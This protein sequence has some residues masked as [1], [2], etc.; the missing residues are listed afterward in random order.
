MR[1]SVIIGR[2]LVASQVVECQG[3]SCVL[4]S[5]CKYNIAYKATEEELTAMMS[6][7]IQGYLRSMSVCGS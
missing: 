4:L 6:T 5:E 7:R 2:V 3:I 1:P